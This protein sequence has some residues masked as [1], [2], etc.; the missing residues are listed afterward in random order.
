MI[1]HG[2]ESCTTLPGFYKSRSGSLI[3]DLAGFLDTKGVKQ[4]ILNSYSNSKMF[5]RGTLLRIVIVMDQHTL[6]QSR[7]G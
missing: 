6:R 1:G 2:N 3:C 5:Q 4:E 7:G